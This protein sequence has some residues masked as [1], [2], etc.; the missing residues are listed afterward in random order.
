MAMLLGLETGTM[1]FMIWF[2]GV[3]LL[4]MISF[5]QRHKVLSQRKSVISRALE[6]AKKTGSKIKGVNDPKGL[7]RGQAQYTRTC[8]FHG[9][10]SIWMERW[11]HSMVSGK[12]RIGLGC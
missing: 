1:C 2:L 8:L 6:I 12:R 4:D 11:G 10:K 3:Q 9:R 5:S 7:L